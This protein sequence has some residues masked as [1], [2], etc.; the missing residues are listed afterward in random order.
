[1]DTSQHYNIISFISYS[2]KKSGEANTNK[3][4]SYISKHRTPPPQHLS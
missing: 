1:M 2:Y 3:P 4:P